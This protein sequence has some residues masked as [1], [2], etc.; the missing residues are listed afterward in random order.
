MLST[1]FLAL[2]LTP[3][4]YVAVLSPQPDVEETSSYLRI[5]QMKFTILAHFFIII[6]CNT[7]LL[8]Q[9]IFFCENKIKE[10]I[11]LAKNM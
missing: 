2:N 8:S 1:D 10:K 5:S 9:I 6:I 4:S 3:V 7:G 11:H